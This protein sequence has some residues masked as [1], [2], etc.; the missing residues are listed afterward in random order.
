MRPA[1]LPPD[2]R[3]ALAAPEKTVPM[4]GPLPRRQHADGCRCDSCREAER[5]TE[6]AR[7][8]GRPLAVEVCDGCCVVVRTDLSCR[9]PMFFG[10][11]AVVEAELRGLAGRGGTC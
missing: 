7:A 11:A 5:L 2:A 6:L 10:P 4:A 3:L 9:L 8:T 1:L